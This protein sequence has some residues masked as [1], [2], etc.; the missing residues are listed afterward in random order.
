LKFSTAPANAFEYGSEGER[1]QS[2]AGGH[3]E[4]S[5]GEII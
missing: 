2:E 5:A 3:S 1:W 4:D